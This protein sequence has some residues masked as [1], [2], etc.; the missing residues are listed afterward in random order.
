MS[1][2]VQSEGFHYKHVFSC[3]LF[4]LA[5]P[6]KEQLYVGAATHQA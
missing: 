2:D 4:A 3:F 5:F 6:K 1:G